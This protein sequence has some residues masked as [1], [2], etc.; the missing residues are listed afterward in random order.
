M[1][2]R[3]RQFP[4]L[5]WLPLTADQPMEV[6]DEQNS[7][8]VRKF[9]AARRTPARDVKIQES[10]DAMARPPRDV[11]LW[12]ELP[13]KLAN[14]VAD[15]NADSTEMPGQPSSETAVRE[16]KERTQQEREEAQAEKA[17]A[18]MDLR[19]AGPS[20]EEKFP[21]ESATKAQARLNTA[22][23]GGTGSY[24]SRPGHWKVRAVWC[25]VCVLVL[26]LLVDCIHPLKPYINPSDDES[27]AE[28]EDR[29]RRRAGKRNDTKEKAS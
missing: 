2:A 12:G 23:G 3:V 19:Q 9:V 10:S 24:S 5:L 15:Q 27:E 22:D 7:A 6:P 4:T 8:A 25:V 20:L 18:A 1:M 29:H 16:R 11:P 14:A 17:F 13:A 21:S 28:D 26:I